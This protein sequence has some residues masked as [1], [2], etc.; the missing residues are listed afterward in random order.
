MLA[1]CNTDVPNVLKAPKP[2]SNAERVPQGTNHLDTRSIQLLPHNP[3]FPAASQLKV[4][5]PEDPLAPKL[6]T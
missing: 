3:L 2:S 4:G 6:A 5:L 1:V